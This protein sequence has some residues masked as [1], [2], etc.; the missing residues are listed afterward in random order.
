MA[1]KISQSEKIVRKDIENY[2]SL[3]A[4]KN[5]EGGQLLIGSLQKDILSCIDV[6]SLKYK[7]S[8]HIELVAICAKLS[9]KIA[10]FRT[11]SRSSKNKKLALDELKLVLE[12]NP[13]NE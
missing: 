12:E 11:I 3:E 4:L 7:D 10:L 1:K 8:S 9:E 2:S 6:I 13:E 5:S